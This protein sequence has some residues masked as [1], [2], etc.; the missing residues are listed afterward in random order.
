MGRRS[1][2]IATAIFVLALSPLLIRHSPAYPTATATGMTGV[3]NGGNGQ[4][5]SQC[6]GANPSVNVSASISGPSTLLP[7]QS[8]TFKLSISSAN[9]NSNSTNGVFNGTFGRVG[10]D[11]AASDPSSLSVISGQPSQILNGEIVH[12]C[13]GPNG[14]TLLSI[15]G[16]NGPGSTTVSMLFRYTMPVTA[17]P[18]SQHTL[19]AVT[20]IGDPPA[21]AIP[22]FGWHHAP[23]FTVTAGAPPS[24]GPDP[25][26]MT[27]PPCNGC[28]P[29]SGQLPSRPYTET[30]TQF[31]NVWAA[32][33]GTLQEPEYFEV[34]MDVTRQGASV[35][36]TGTI[37]YPNVLY[38]HTP[39]ALQVLR[40]QNSYTF[41]TPLGPSAR[42]KPKPVASP[43]ATVPYTI[44]VSLRTEDGTCGPT[45][46]SDTNCV[47]NVYTVT[48]LFF[49]GGTPQCINLLGAAGQKR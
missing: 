6:H 21:F 36:S 19:Y 3:T 28:P 30:I 27:D 49:P 25:Y 44:Q 16:T 37:V 40:F 46:S 41:K 10:Y 2:L 35:C 12:C 26:V 48:T 11:I 38:S 39:P 45:S 43:V 32:V 20:N 4:G 23:S 22:N 33:N 9:T 29:Q 13:S 17:V 1:V 24:P 7:S 31:V 34:N 14:S 15:G 18:N 8:G 47:N 5:C 42:L